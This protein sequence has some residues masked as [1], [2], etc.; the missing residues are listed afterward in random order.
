MLFLLGLIFY[1]KEPRESH[2]RRN[3]LFK[4]IRCVYESL[5][6]KLFNRHNGGHFLTN[7]QYK[8]GEQF[9]I[10]VRSVL[11]IIKLF[12]PLPIYWALLAQQDSSWTF[13]ATK[14]NTMIGPWKLEPDQMKAIAPLILL[15]LI[16][17]WDRIILPAIHR[18]TRFEITPVASIALGGIAAA[19]AFICSGFLEEAVQVSGI[20]NLLTLKNIL[21]DVSHFP[22]I[23]D[24]GSF[25][26]MATST[27]HVTDGR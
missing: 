13:Q 20:Y 19:A 10:S 3:I 11:H 16:P 23:R 12:L 24:E 17:L 8:Y 22:E 21:K 2:H 9:I 25:Y 4:V 27:I 18:N 1:V 15:G 7:I 5:K 6:R 14:L 26:P